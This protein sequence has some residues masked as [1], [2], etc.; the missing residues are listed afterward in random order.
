MV[1][2]MSSVKEAI[3]YTKEVKD[4]CLE[5]KKAGRSSQSIHVEFGP[6]VNSI[7]KWWKEYKNGGKKTTI[8]SSDTL[9]LFKLAMKEPDLNKMVIELAMNDATII[10]TVVD[11]FKEIQEA[12]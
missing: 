8:I 10:Q 11:K 2:I 12:A 9:W 7:N 3:R 6:T 5:A 4:Q 1:I